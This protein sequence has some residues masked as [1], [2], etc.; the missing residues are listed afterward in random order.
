MRPRTPQAGPPSPSLFPECFGQLAQASTPEAT[1]PDGA[2]LSYSIEGGNASGLFEIDAASGELFYVGAGEDFDAGTGSFELA[3]RAS[4]GD[5]FTDTSV[6]VG[7]A[8]VQEAPAFGQQRS[9]EGRGEERSRGRST[10]G[11]RGGVRGGCRTGRARRGACHH[12]HHLREP[13]HGPAVPAPSGS[14][15]PARARA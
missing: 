6:V 7:V 2:A 13:L 1:D 3:V 15:T 11:R 8:D 4:D 14:V 5:L 9:D 10:H 12:R